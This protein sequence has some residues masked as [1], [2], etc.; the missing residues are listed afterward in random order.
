MKLT[1]LMLSAS[2]AALA[3][4]SCNKNETTPEGDTAPR[5]VEISFENIATK[6]PAG[7]KIHHN[8]TPVVVNDL[9]IFLTDESYSAVYKAWNKNQTEEAKFYWSKEDLTSGIPTAEFHYVDHKCTRVIAVA[10]MKDIKFDDLKKFTEVIGEQQDQKDL[11]LL[12]YA[13]LNKT[14]ETHTLDNSKKYTEVYSAEL[15]LKPAISR[16]E[17]DGFVMDYNAEDK[18]FNTV[19]VVDVAFLHYYPTVA[20]S[21]ANHV[22]EFIATGAHVEEDLDLTNVAAV[23][24]WLG[25][26]STQGWYRDSYSGE[27]IMTPDDPTTTDKKEN[28]ADVPSPRA[29]HFFSGDL[30][31]VMLIRLMV[32]GNPT[33]IYT[34]VFKNQS[35]ETIDKLEPGKIYR[36]S[37]PGIKDTA[38]GSVIIPEDKLDPVERCLDI[39]VKVVNW[40]VEL[41][42]PTF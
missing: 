34:N 1:N 17:L 42:T 7:D 38:D 29:Y 24:E 12:D 19:E 3:L 40:Q 5:S 4:V 23:M 36:M 20:Y 26:E 2:I 27:I 25:H 9:K 10:N 35:G 28:M 32:D 22:P 21:T 6:G 33:Y 15:T 41:V 30:A 31:P 18:D 37:A 14:S 39:T 13:E 16:F 8:T 11:I